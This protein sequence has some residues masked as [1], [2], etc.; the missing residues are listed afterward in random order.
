[1]SAWGTILANVDHFQNQDSQTDRQTKGQKD[2][3]TLGFVSKMFIP[4]FIS[5]CTSSYTIVKSKVDYSF[6]PEFQ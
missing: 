5:V 2:R 4:A 6:E 1:M 3:Y